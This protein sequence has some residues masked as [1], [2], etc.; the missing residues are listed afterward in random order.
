MFTLVN[1]VVISA[2]AVPIPAHD[3]SAAAD[4]AHLPLLPLGVQ[5]R[6]LPHSAPHGCLPTAG[7]VAHDCR[8][9]VF[10][11]CAGAAVQGIIIIMFKVRLLL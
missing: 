2:G 7:H 10:L 3:S 11:Q 6:L 9:Q 1:I 5:R 4:I 8:Q